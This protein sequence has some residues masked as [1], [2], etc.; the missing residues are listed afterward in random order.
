MRYDL[1]QIKS[2][3]S[4][5]AD[6]AK[7]NMMMDFRGKQIAGWAKTALDHGLYT[8]VA[9]LDVNSLDEAFQVGNIGPEEQIT[10]HDRMASISVG[11]VLI[12]EDGF[13][14]VVANFGFKAVGINRMVAA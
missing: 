9:T 14:F 5:E 4:L 2:D 7:T 3:T 6:K 1:Y 12:N 13:M 10:R 11:D 8:K